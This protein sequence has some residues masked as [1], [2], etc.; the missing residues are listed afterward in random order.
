MGVLEAREREPQVVEPLLERLTRDANAERACVGEVG[1]RPRRLGS[2][3]WRENHILFGAAERDRLFKDKPEARQKTL[4]HSMSKIARLGGYLARAGDRPPDNT[5][6][7]A[8]C[9]A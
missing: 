2:C 4:S 8:G 7:C 9:H 5:V 1:Q 6:M 3:S